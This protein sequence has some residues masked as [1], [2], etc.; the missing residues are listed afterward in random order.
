ME[1]REQTLQ[2]VLDKDKARRDAMYS[3]LSPE[4]RA[5]EESLAR[6]QALKVETY[7]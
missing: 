7:K 5:R 6:S 4:R 2:A 1:E 3:H